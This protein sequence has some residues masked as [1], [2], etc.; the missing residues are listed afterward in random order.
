MRKKTLAVV[1]AVISAVGLAG[2]FGHIQYKKCT[3]PD[4]VLNSPADITDELISKIIDNDINSLTINYE[5]T[6]CRND[7]EEMEDWEKFRLKNNP[8][9]RA[10]QQKALTNISFKV[11]LASNVHSL[12]CAFYDMRELEFVN[13]DDTSNLTNMKGMFYSAIS[14]NQPIGSWDTSSV[15]DMSW[16]FAW[17][18]SF[19]QPIG[20][21]DTSKVTN[22]CAMFAGAKSFNQPIGNWNTSNV[23][24]M[25][26]MF[27]IAK[28]FNQPIGNWD[29][30]KVTDMSE[31]FSNATSFNQPISNWDTSKV[32]DMS[33]MFCFARSFNQPIGNWD[34][35][36][37]T[38]MKG[39]FEG[40]DAY[41]HPEPKG[42]E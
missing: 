10:N 20:N 33:R 41:S 37:V 29:T 22:M 24:N 38:D 2:Y 40:A 25:K 8:F 31:M 34:T 17:A 18:E 30:S 9:W 32:T 12:A 16:M 28:S 5:F 26:L 3:A 27:Y 42:A 1:G 21:W 36:K 7:N 35:S 19:N 13:L 11:K 6:R 14:F 23:T 4:F 15:K 39:M